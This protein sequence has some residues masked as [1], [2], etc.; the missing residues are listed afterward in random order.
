MDTIAQMLTKIRNAQM[1]GHKEVEI[2]ASRLKLAIA[3]ILEKEGFV[4]SVSKE[5]ND[6]FEIIKIGL[7]YYQVSNTRKTPAIKGIQRV[8]KEGQRIYLKK[9]EIK[10]VKNKFGI[11]IISTSRGVMTGEESRKLGLGGEY[12]CEVW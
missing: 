1:A 7:K 6:N 3:R 8:S 9:K 10:N 2:N 11:A 5:K 12:I 4:E